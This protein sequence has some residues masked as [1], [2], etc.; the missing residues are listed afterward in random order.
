MTKESAVRLRP[1]F[2]MQAYNR[3]AEA[4]MINEGATATAVTPQA[5]ILGRR[6][7]GT[8]YFRSKPTTCADVKNEGASGNDQ[9]LSYGKTL[10]KRMIFSTWQD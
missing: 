1:P 3:M 9:P 2:A 8:S 10:S 7:P 4:G 6:A 5:F